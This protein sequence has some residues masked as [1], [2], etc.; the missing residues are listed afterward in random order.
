MRNFDFMAKR[1]LPMRDATE[2]VC[3]VRRLVGF[4]QS[5]QFQNIVPAA[6]FAARDEREVARQ[7]FV[8]AR[9][10]PDRDSTG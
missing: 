10:F 3:D 2:Q 6:G 4:R 7:D 8:A 5:E 9:A 1:L